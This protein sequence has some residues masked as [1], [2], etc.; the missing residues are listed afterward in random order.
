M[1]LMIGHREPKMLALLLDSC[2]VRIDGNVSVDVR[3]P[4]ELVRWANLLSEPVAFAWRSSVTGARHLEVCGSSTDEPVDG[5]VWV[6]LDGDLHRDV[7]DAV[8]KDD[9]GCGQEEPI[10]LGQVRQAARTLED[11]PRQDLPAA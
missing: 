4:S 10:D 11:R 7:W 3:G 6:V 5:Y 9:L 1:V 8:L 2:A